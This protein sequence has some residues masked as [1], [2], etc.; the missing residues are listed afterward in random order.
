MKQLQRLPQLPEYHEIKWREIQNDEY[1]RLITRFPTFD[2]KTCPTCKGALE[3][4]YKGEVWDCDCRTQ[5]ALTKHYL[6]ANL[7]KAYHT[8]SFDDLRTDKQE[9][10]EAIH[11]YVDNWPS[12]QHYGRGI[13]FHGGLGTGKTLA[14][15]LILKE[16]VKTGVRCWFTSFN[17][18]MNAY[19]Y[20]DEKRQF[21][22]E[23][24]TADCA[25]IDEIPRPVSEKQR[26]LYQEVLEWLTRYRVENA[27]P[28][29]MATNIHELDTEYPRIGSLIDMAFLEY[30]VTGPDARRTSSREEIKQL[31][32]NQET[33]PVK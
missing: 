31:I 2:R 1:D 21:F 29:L 23:L 17:A 12:Y 33:R 14:I 11:D 13:L 5:I 18:A 32:H 25:A 10:G 9:L 3:F 16:L 20:S 15:V 26:D 22:Q 27:L 30:E 4:K 19:M 24:K 6:Y 28:T 8:L 7:G